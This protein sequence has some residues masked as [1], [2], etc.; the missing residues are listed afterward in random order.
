MDPSVSASDMHSPFEG[1]ELE[2]PGW[3]VAEEKS[4]GRREGYVCKMPAQ[5]THR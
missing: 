3:F 2:L 5:R 1:R 4:G